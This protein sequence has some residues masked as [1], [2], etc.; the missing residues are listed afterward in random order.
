MSIQQKTAGRNPRSTVG[1][2]TEVADFLRVLYARLGQGHCVR[3]GRLITAQTREQIIGA[4][5]RYRK[6][7][8]SNFWLR[9]FAGKKASSKTSSPT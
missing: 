8:A 9:S 3:C 2:I 1:T 5:W 4:F 7:H 6:E